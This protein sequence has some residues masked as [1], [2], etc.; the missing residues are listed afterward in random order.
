[1]RIFREMA[2]RRYAK[3]SAQTLCR[4]AVW[5]S[6]FVSPGWETY[7]SFK[8]EAPREDT[9]DAQTSCLR[10]RLRSGARGRR[11]SERYADVDG[12]DGSDHEHP[13]RYHGRSVGQAVLA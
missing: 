1:M 13:I 7:A 2:F 8:I 12:S 10:Y 6:A 9:I 4:D 5:C 3:P 11:L